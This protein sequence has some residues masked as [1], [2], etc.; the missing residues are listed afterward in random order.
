MHLL[1]TVVCANLGARVPRLRY[2]TPAYDN[3]NASHSPIAAQ[4]QTYLVNL[5]FFGLEKNLNARPIRGEAQTYSA[6]LLLI[7]IYLPKANG[8]FS[9]NIIP[10]LSPSSHQPK[11]IERIRMVLL[12]RGLSFLSM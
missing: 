5:D 8:R 12:Q 6:I 10:S 4:A 7:Q 1:F 9:L 11:S 2:P 3:S